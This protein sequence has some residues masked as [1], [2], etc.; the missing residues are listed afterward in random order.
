[1]KTQ[2]AVPAGAGDPL[3]CF[4]PLLARRGRTLH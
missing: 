3:G 4:L 2:Q 1:M